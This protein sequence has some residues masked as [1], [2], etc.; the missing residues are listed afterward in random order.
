MKNK[1]V[2]FVVRYSIKELEK[3]T[4]CIPTN[5]LDYSYLIPKYGYIVY[6]KFY[7]LMPKDIKL[8]MLP[9]FTKLLQRIDISNSKG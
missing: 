6:S 5:I 9:S 3:C 7:H 8:K 1:A 2:K 4:F